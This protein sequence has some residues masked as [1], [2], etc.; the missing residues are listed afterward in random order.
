MLFHAPKYE[1]L[2]SISFRLPWFLTASSTVRALTA[3][4]SL[5]SSA[6]ERI[7]AAIRE[8]GLP[9]S[10]S[11]LTEKSRQLHEELKV[12][13][14][15]TLLSILDALTDFIGLPTEV[16]PDVLKDLFKETGIPFAALESTVK[17]LAAD[18]QLVKQRAIREF[19]N[20]TL[21]GIRSVEHFCAIR[22]RFDQDFSYNAGKIENYAPK[23]VDYHPAVVIKIL[24]AESPVE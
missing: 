15:E 5:D 10:K 9:F 6:Q 7:K 20:L 22:T 17:E 12:L 1:D 13:D 21:P 24:L 2:M 23:V 18:P 19:K 11:R 16:L 3:F 14:L 8:M 4:L